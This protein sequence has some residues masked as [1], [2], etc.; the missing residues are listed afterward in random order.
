MVSVCGKEHIVWL[1]QGDR[2][3]AGGFLSYIDVVMPTKTTVSMEPNEAFLEMP[4]KQH[5]SALAQ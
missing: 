1:E 3:N 4:D 5:L 2:G